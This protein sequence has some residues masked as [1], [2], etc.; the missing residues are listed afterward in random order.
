MEG[1]GTVARATTKEE[2]IKTAHEFIDYI[3]KIDKIPHLFNGI[4]LPHFC[5]SPEEFNEVRDQIGDE[6]TWTGTDD[7]YRE[8]QVSFGSHTLHVFEGDQV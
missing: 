8:I 3:A 5:G 4:F 2:W 7:P 1:R 6:V